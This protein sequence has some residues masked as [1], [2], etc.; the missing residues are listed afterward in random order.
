M[1]EDSKSLKRTIYQIVKKSTLPSISMP[2][3]LSGAGA[4]A[5]AAAAAGAGAAD[6]DAGDAGE[7]E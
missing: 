6:E 4:A 5:G 2:S 1:T 7:A 3:M